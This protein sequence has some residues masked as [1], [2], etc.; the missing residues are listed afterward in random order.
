MAG[1]NALRERLLD[2]DFADALY[3]YLKNED[4]FKEG[5]ER[6]WLS[7]LSDTAGFVAKLRGQGDV[8]TD[9]YPHGGRA[10]LN[11]RAY[12]A[13]RTLGP[14]EL[15]PDETALE[16]LLTARFAEIKIMLARLGWRLATTEDR[17]IAAAATRRDLASWE[18]RPEGPAPDWVAKIQAPRSPPP[19]ALRL[20]G[21]H[22]SQM[23]EAERARDQ[24]ITT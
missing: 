20:L 16:A 21:V 10:P 1:D 4:F 23:T 18:A 5:G 2:A 15:T 6:I 7:G 14:P 12:A 13:R 11:D 3:G 17:K 22:P 24:E 8:Y 9:Y 19:G